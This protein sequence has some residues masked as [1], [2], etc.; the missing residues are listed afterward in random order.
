MRDEDFQVFIDE[1]G[2]ATQRTDV[3]NESVEKWRGK[4]PAQLLKYWQEEGWC[5][6]ANGL[7]WTVNPEEYEDLVNEWLHDTAF[8]QLDSFHVIARSAF[9]ELYACGEKTGPKLKI[10]CPTHALIALA[11]DLHP[12]TSE[13][14]DFEIRGLFGNRM[15]EDCDLKDEDRKPLFERALKKLGPLA[16]DEMYGFEPAIIAGGR[17]RLENL[18]KV[19]LDQHLTILRQLAAPQI[20]FSKVDIEKL[21]PR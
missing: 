3:P 1:F 11:K 4:L 21:L 2:E 12:K 17:M 13:R 9:G 7:L 18:R 10:L 8:E 14:L 5:A 15:K 6:Y 20:P 16:S 19:K